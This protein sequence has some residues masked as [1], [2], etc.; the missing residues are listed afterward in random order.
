MVNKRNVKLCLLFIAIE[1]TLKELYTQGNNT[2]QTT[3]FTTLGNSVYHCMQA[4][5]VM[6]NAQNLPLSGHTSHSAKATST[7]RKR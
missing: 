4:Q 6:H 2:V 7:M 5:A 1:D 3:A